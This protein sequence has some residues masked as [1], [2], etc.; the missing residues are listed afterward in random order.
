LNTKRLREERSL[1][2]RTRDKA[3]AKRAS[4]RTSAKRAR[5][6]APAMRASEARARRGRIMRADER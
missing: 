5:E 4:K 2:T 3:T 6:S 1:A